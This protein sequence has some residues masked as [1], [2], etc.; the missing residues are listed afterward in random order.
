MGVG[1]GLGYAVNLPLAPFTDDETYLWAFRETV[2]PL[3]AAF[4]PDVVVSQLGVDTHRQDPLAHLSLTTQ[5]YAAVVKELKNLAP[6]WLA[7]GG[8]GYEMGVVARAW[9]LA[10]GV[11]AG[12]DWP[13]EIPLEY[14]ERYGLKRL[15]DEGQNPNTHVPQEKAQRFAQASVE[16]IKKRVFPF[17]R[18]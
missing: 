4:Q 1:E 10:F 13:D 3:I 5:G 2:I 12:K 14:Q 16:E 17:H 9:A 7:L 15:R 6:R 11:M 18:L 8:G